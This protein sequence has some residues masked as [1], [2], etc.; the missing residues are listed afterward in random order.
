[1]KQTG[2]QQTLV[3][4][5]SQGPSGLKLWDSEFTLDQGIGIAAT[6]LPPRAWDAALPGLTHVYLEP[7]CSRSHG[8]Y[9]AVLGTASAQY[10]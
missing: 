3:G 2:Q 1:M 9:R 6:A 10:A 7:R 4:E 8:L 5:F